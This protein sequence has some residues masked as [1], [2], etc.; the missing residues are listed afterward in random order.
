MMDLHFIRPELLWLLP[1]IIP[2]LLLAWRKQVQGG[3]WAKAIDPTCYPTSSR[4]KVAV[5]VDYV[6]CGGSPYPFY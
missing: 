4:P 6:S 2:L 3:D 5:V 1:V